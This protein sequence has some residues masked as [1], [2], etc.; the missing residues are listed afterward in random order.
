MRD[1][2][3]FLGQRERLG[4]TGRGK[5]GYLVLLDGDPLVGPTCLPVPHVFGA[6]NILP[7]R[8]VWL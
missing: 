5:Y 7:N 2:V 1:A 4:T 6:P 8:S 3:E